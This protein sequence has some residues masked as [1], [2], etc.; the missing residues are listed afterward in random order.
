VIAVSFDTGNLQEI[1]K[2]IEAVR[3]RARKKKDV[4]AKRLIAEGRE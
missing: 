3:R 2:G 1:F 4:S